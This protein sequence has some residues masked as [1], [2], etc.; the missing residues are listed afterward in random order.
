[1]QE[2]S[3][4]QRLPD[5]DFR[6]EV[7]HL[8]TFFTGCP[9]LCVRLRSLT[10][11]WSCINSHASLQFQYVT[12]DRFSFVSLVRFCTASQAAE[13]WEGIWAQTR[14]ECADKEGPSSR[15]LI[16][17]SNKEK[18]Q[19]APIYDQYENHCRIK[20]VSRKDGTVILRLTCFEFWQ[21]FK[22]NRSG[23]PVSVKIIYQDQQHISIDG[24]RYQRCRD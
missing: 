14:Q 2:S 18:G 1:M 15:T 12:T 22:N 24:E 6:S 10:P 4:L 5:Y 11:L 13:R 16:D 7:V 8:P 23:R 9:I 17:L 20:G 21:E 19:L 3:H